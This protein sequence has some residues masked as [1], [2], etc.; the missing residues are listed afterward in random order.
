MEYEPSSREQK[1]YVLIEAGLDIISDLKIIEN[2]KNKFK[3]K[4][5]NLD[6]HGRKK[7]LYNIN[8]PQQF[9]Q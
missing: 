7:N 3:I 1:G 8:L 5:I 4:R 2:C 6:N 9:N